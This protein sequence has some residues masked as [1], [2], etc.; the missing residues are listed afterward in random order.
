MGSMEFRV[1]AYRKTARILVREC[2]IRFVIIAVVAALVGRIE[3]AAPAALW[4][5]SMAGMLALEAGLF[6]HFF[7]GA[8]AEVG[9]RLMT[10]LGAVSLACNL[11]A[12]YPLAVFMNDGGAPAYFA[13]A[14]YMS[15]LL[16]NLV[17]NNGAHPVIFG[18]AAAPAALFYLGASL[19]VSL[20]AGDPTAALTAA[21][22]VAAGFAAYL[23]LSR[24]MQEL[25]VAAA[26][27]KRERE[28]AERA[29]AAKSQFLAKMS[30]E[31]R[32][33]LNAI[34]GIAQAI[35]SDRLSA[36]QKD[37]LQ[38][39]VNAGDELLSMLNDLL[40]HAAVEKGALILRPA[41]DD[42]GA[43][44]ARAA[45]RFRAEATRKGLELSV[46]VGAG[47]RV[48]VDAAHLDKAVTHL[49]HNAV[50]FTDCGG[51]RVALRSTP[52]GD[53][54]FDVV[55]EVADDGAGMD[56]EQRVRVFEPFEQSDNSIRR[57]HGGAG[58][59]LTVARNIARAMGGDIDAESAPGK[60]STFRIRFAAQKAAALAAAAP[61]A[62]P[63]VLVVEDN[64]V[65][66]QVVKAMLNSRARLVA[67]AEN[68]AVA[69]TRLHAERFDVILMDMHMPVMDGLEATREI[70]AADAAWS[71]TPIIFVTAAA[72]D[73]D[74]RAAV[75]AG[76]D[77]FVPKPVKA[78][79]LDRALATA[80]A[81][82]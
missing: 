11:V 75:G 16:V 45:E 7:S 36:S 30:H 6:R 79:A 19:A 63:S 60:G 32:T 31:F 22:S 27:A 58:L 76:A 80:R 44:V 53:D 12:L 50:K 52:A 49:V 64:L 24:T 61:E 38:I 46:D 3:G 43:I 54:R 35:A 1:D 57:R 8:R 65:N 10:L 82:A 56:D 33:P 23:A 13:A 55:V 59:G 73:A 20:R 37:R 62:Q 26:D 28:A 67:H 34:L 9:P 77:A 5:A 2:P 74:E 40:D 72:S 18:A 66:F 71:R 39:I 15:G 47:G 4:Y 69:L 78:E 48:L 17:V 41:A 25:R 51:V 21:G 29:S 70:R 81:R 42:L 68:G 14:A